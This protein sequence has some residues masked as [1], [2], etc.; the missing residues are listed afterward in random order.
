MTVQELYQ[1]VKDAVERNST[2]RGSSI[3]KRQFVDSYNTSIVEYVYEMLE[4]RNSD[5]TRYISDLRTFKDIK[6][7]SETERYSLFEKPDNYL[8]FIDLYC[9]FD[10]SE[11]K[12]TSEYLQEIK[13]EEA[14]I[15][16]TDPNY[17]PS[18]EYGESM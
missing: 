1:Y 7:L 5:M 18:F 3:T 4:N 11:C 16:Y 14:N 12:I 2:Y 17:E 9:E 10:N 15:Y 8:S 6:F 13:P